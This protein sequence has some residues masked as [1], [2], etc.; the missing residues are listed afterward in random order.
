[1]TQDVLIIGAG[2]AG[3]N[4][5]RQLTAAGQR[6]ALVDS[7]QQVGGRCASLELH[8]QPVDHGVPLLHGHREAFI[9]DVTEAAGQGLVPDWPAHLR[10]R[11]TPCQPRAFDFRSWRAGL[12]QGVGSFPRWL[13]RGLQVRL[14]A[15]VERLTLQ[16][17]HF[18]AL[19]AGGDRLEAGSVMVTCPA[20]Q[21]VQL[22][23]PLASQSEELDGVVRM[24]GG[25]FTLPCLTVVA[26]YQRAP[27]RDG[28]QLALPGPGSAAHSLI[29][30]SSKRP[31]AAE[32][33]LVIQGAPAF[34]RLQLEHEPEQWA[35]LLLQAAADELGDWALEPAW[36]HPHR[37]R[38]ARI[39][40][41]NLLQIPLL[42][43][44]PGGA[45]LG[46]CGE[47]F[48]PIG[49]VEGAFISGRELARRV[50][51]GSPTAATTPSSE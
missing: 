41:E 45:R 36:Q 38:H 27:D 35:P 4:L 32:Q 11:G 51:S 43:G 47:A 37:W 24:L 23:T 39:S 50:L 13:A 19:L 10:G 16:G 21:T 14:D 31:D 30:D 49:G 1:M 25:V 29:N 28:W 15:T 26:G 20:P 9:S 42:L 22:L 3:L 18:E 6:V 5:A 2:V 33:V 46:L 34:S 8:G 7:G 12:A 17:D 48:S 44:W 40:P